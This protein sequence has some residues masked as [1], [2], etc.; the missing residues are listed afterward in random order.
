MK[1]LLIDYNGIKFFMWPLKKETTLLLFILLPFIANSQKRNDCDLESINRW[2]KAFIKG[3]TFECSD[4]ITE[5]NEEFDNEKTLKKNWQTFWGNGPKAEDHRMGRSFGFC[6]ENLWLDENVEV[7][8]GQCIIYGRYEPD[9]EWIN[10]RGE[11]FFRDFTTG[12]IMTKKKF[13]LGRFETTITD[14]PG[15]GWHATFWM[16]HHEEIDIM[17]RFNREYQYLYNSY[18]SMQCDDKNIVQIDEIPENPIPISLFDGPHKPAADLT[19]F[20]LT[21]Y[22]NDI[23]L[24]SVV[25]RFYKSNGTPLDIDCGSQ[26]PEGFYYVNPNFPKLYRKKVDKSGN[27]LKPEPKYFQPT[28]DMDALPKYGGKCCPEF[29]PNVYCDDPRCHKECSNWGNPIK[30]GFER[31]GYEADTEMIIDNVKVETRVYSACN[32]LLVIADGEVCENYEATLVVEDLGSHSK[33]YLVDNLTATSS[34]NIEVISITNHEIKILGLSRGLGLI[35]ISYTDKCDNSN[36]LLYPVNV[37][38]EGSGRC[39]N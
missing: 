27:I 22:Y 38:S 33:R 13:Q 11:T 39:S 14:M 15:K 32:S 31:P 6:D 18:T 7:F 36:F 25:Y 35:N 12:V 24:P 2:Q 29:G 28:I 17:E 3:G 23:K 10:G 9:T 16:W 4:W 20:K 26:I 34:S 19:P 8:D 5:I 30:D 1:L 37:I 21:F